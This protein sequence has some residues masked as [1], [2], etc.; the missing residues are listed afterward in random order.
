MHSPLNVKFR[1]LHITLY[2]HI[3]CLSFSKNLFSFNKQSHLL[4]QSRSS[5]SE[6]NTHEPQIYIFIQLSITH[7]KLLV[8][9]L[10]PIVSV[11]RSSHHQAKNPNDTQ[12]FCIYCPC[13]VA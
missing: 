8:N 7:K 2:M 5:D 11:L 1:I 3:N 13:E 10:G 6:L 12:R 9:F 4:V